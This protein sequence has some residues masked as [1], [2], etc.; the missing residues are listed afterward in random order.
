VPIPLTTGI[1]TKQMTAQRPVISPNS[2]V[3][4]VSS[5]KT[6]V[7]HTVK[8]SKTKIDRFAAER[9]DFYR[10]KNFMHV[11]IDLLFLFGTPLPHVLIPSPPA[12]ENGQVAAEIPY[13][14]S[15]TLGGIIQL[16]WLGR[17]R[18]H[19]EILA[20]T[21]EMPSLDFTAS[22]GTARLEQLGTL[23]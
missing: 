9:Y 2:K 20:S 19:L 14:N 1:K 11:S 23:R 21:A 13:L 6:R 22:S 10:W 5:T 3:C 12:I 16:Q 4:N 17:P 8:E 15:T 18:S 7:A